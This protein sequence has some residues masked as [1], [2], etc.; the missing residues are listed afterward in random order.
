MFAVKEKCPHTRTTLVQAH[1]LIDYHL[2]EEPEE[3]PIKV[4]FVAH[5]CD[6]CGLITD[7][8]VT[9]GEVERVG[10]LP[11]LDEPSYQDAIEALYR[12]QATIEVQALRFMLWAV[13]A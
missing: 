2:E 8:P 10:S 1:D 3:K 4:W 5:Q 11:W 13:R 7:K 6:H 12:P 9:A